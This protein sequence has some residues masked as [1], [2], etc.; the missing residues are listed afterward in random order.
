MYKSA[1]RSDPLLLQAASLAHSLNADLAV[2]V[3]FVIPADGPGCC[4]IRGRAW[5]DMLRQVADEEAQRARRVL[6]EAGVP[7]TVTVLDGASVPEI[8]EGFVAAAD[9]RL[10]LP[11]KASGTAFSRSDL[12]RLAAVLGV[13]LVAPA[14]HA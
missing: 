12:R 1:K 4:G 2:V 9:R 7:H 14:H 3:P 13:V 10:A 6:H 8:V 5:Q 11:A